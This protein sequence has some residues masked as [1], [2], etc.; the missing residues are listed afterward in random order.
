MYSLS[1]HTEN[2]LISKVLNLWFLNLHAVNLMLISDFCANS[3][4]GKEASHKPCVFLPPKQREKPLTGRKAPDADCSVVQS[5]KSCWVFGFFHFW[6]A[7]NITGWTSWLLSQHWVCAGLF[8]Q[9][10]ILE[11]SEFCALEWIRWYQGG[12][13]CSVTFC[14]FQQVMS[15]WIILHHPL[16]LF[17]TSWSWAV[18]PVFLL[19]LFL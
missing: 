3:E 10:L 1:L 7:V 16:F 13:A 5:L 17:C 18:C 2:F 14:T 8:P 19:L 6:K 11:T 4:T 9:D 12:S 15:G